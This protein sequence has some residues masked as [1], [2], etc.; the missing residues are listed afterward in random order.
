MNENGTLAS[1]TPIVSVAV[2]RTRFSV[3]MGAAGSAATAT[4]VW[5]WA[6]RG[7]ANAER[8]E[9]GRQYRAVEPQDVHTA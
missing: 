5:S 9:A 4:D 8:S 7:A 1:R 6:C 2:S 3:S